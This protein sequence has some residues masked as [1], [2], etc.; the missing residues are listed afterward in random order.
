MKLERRIS[1]SQTFIHFNVL[2]SDVIIRKAMFGFM[3]RITESDNVLIVTLVNS[4]NYLDS[5]RFNYW[6]ENLF[7]TNM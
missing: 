1:M 7:V 2:H 5:S 6:S 3:N 4:S